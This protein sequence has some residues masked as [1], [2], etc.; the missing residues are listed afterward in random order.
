ME[1]NNSVFRIENLSL[2]PHDTATISSEFRTPLNDANTGANNIYRGGGRIFAAGWN[3]NSVSIFV[4][5]DRRR[6]T[7]I[8]VY[9]SERNEFLR[10]TFKKVV[11]TSNTNI[12]LEEQFFLFLGGY[13]TIATR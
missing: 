1:R 11:D 9:G 4:R 5:I 12:W 13:G 8:V 6:N 7:A 10:V 2:F 3:N